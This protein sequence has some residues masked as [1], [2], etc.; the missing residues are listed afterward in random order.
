M[1]F[2]EKLQALRKEKGLTQE[3]LA[4]RLYV[5]R[6]AVSKWESGKGYP[7][8][9]SIKD[10]AAFFSITIDELLSSERVLSLAEKENKQNIRRIC[11]LL[12]GI[13]DLLT[14]LLIVLPLYPNTAD[15]RIYSVSL[16]DYMEIS[17]FNAI[18]YW[19]I[20]VALIVAG[21]VKILLV[22]LNAEKGQKLVSWCSAGIGI[23]GVLF[24]ILTRQVYAPVILFALLVIKAVLYLK[25]AKT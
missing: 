9:D 8:I 22:Q 7:S 20:F 24:L 15:G 16:P 25:Y 23:S 13:L 21:A 6:T 19:V 3:E 11:N 12:F 14:L 18:V 10:I 5:S 1:D 2:G 4:E 17:L